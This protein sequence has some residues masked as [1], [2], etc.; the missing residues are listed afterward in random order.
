MHGGAC[1]GGLEVKLWECSGGFCSDGG[2]SMAMMVEMVAIFVAD[3]AANG[4]SRWCSKVVVREWLLG[5][6]G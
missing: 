6:K 2:S 3:S 5:L 1:D 4:G